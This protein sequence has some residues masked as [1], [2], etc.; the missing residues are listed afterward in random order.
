MSPE[1]YAKRIFGEKPSPTEAGKHAFVEVLARDV[2]T[3]EI[4]RQDNPQLADNAKVKVI[5]ELSRHVPP[6]ILSK[7]PFPEDIEGN[8]EKL[9]VIAEEYI[10]RERPEA[11]KEIIDQ[12]IPVRVVN[13]DTGKVIPVPA[14]EFFNVSNEDSTDNET[15]RAEPETVVPQQCDPIT[16]RTMGAKIIAKVNE[17][18]RLPPKP[19][20]EMLP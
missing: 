4:V 12:S 2:A 7:L 6:D 3:V 10:D 8:L 18:L 14:A 19:P 5:H 13:S 1:G 16:R 17:F 15:P 9:E 11:E 20:T